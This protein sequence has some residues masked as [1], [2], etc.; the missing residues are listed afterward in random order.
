M[1]GF[2]LA[3]SELRRLRKV[4]RNKSTT[5]VK[6]NVRI[7]KDL[8]TEKIGIEVSRQAEGQRL[9][10]EQVDAEKGLAAG[11]CRRIGQWKHSDRRHAKEAEG[12]ESCFV[13]YCTICNLKQF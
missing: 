1:V 7:V 10:M 6:N 11:E 8:V 4:Q 3:Q 5:V 2:K 12:Q 9:A 13:V